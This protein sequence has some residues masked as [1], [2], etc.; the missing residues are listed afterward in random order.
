MHRT[1]AMQA[2]K[3]I[4][5]Q[6]AQNKSIYRKYAHT[7]Y[8]PPIVLSSGFLKIFAQFLLFL[9]KNILRR[10]CDAL[11]GQCHSARKNAR[12][13][14]IRAGVR[15]QIPCSR[16]ADAEMIQQSGRLERDL[17]AQAKLQGTRSHKVINFYETEVVAHIADKSAG[18]ELTR[19]TG[20]KN[21]VQHEGIV[22]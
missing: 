13:Q 14:R 17:V 1:N 21:K 4:S 3:R 8:P 15:R 19:R 6:S 12:T 2:R 10:C 18:S 7:R 5:S 9:K 16:S 22:R 20:T 11:S